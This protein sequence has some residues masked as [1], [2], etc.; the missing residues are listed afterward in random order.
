MDSPL[1]DDG[2]LL[3]YL[4]GEDLPHVAQAM[5]QSPQLRQEL[6][7]LRRAAGLMGRLFDGLGRPEPQDLVDVIT[8]QASP[9]QQLRVAAYLRQSPAAQA[10][11]AALEQEHR[12]LV[13]PPQRRRLRLPEFFALPVGLA[14]G[15]RAS[16]PGS[17]DRDRSFVV[18]ELQAQVTLRIAQRAG[19]QW[20]LEGYLTVQQAPA[21]AVPVRLVAP[22]ARPRPRLSDASG[23]FAFPRLRPGTYEL[24]ATLPQGVLV[25]RALSLRD[26]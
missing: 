26:E 9:Q 16:A 10:E 7:V 12:D 23:F 1:L 25:V 15:L 18:A 6:E 11:Y 2:D 20:A 22:G 8:G 5:A 21:A 24:R 17:D 19:E 14:P 4:E 13:A 3:A